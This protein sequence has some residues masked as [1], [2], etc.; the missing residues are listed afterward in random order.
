MGVVKF[1]QIGL[2]MSLSNEL[3]IVRKVWKILL[4]GT[5]KELVTVL[6]N[7]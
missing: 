7:K 3:Q 1:F 4:G 5:R 6:L 2:I